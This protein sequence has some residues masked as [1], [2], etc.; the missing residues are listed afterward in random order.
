MN[1]ILNMQIEGENNAAWLTITIG[2]L[3]KIPLLKRIAIR[4][5]VE[6]LYVSSKPNYHSGQ[7]K[8]KSRNFVY[9]KID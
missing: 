2:E 4:G 6:Q 5:K 1:T 7:L 3:K 8:R 9:L